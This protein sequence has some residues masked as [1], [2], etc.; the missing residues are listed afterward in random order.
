MN[1]EVI[2]SRY[3]K[4]LLSYVM[5]R[6][7]EEKVYSQVE[8]ILQNMQDVP[9]FRE[10]ILM[11]DDISFS[12]K[13]SLLTTAV[14]EP[15]ADELL[16]FIKLVS[17]HRRMELLQVMFWAFI[18]RYREAKGIKVGALATAFPADG[19]RE[20]METMLESRISSTVHLSEEVDSELIGG[21]VIE[22]DGYRLDASVR[23]QLKKIS[24]EL[25]DKGSRIV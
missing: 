23:T 24:E 21:F 7:V 17:G 11:H 16:N 6:G 8:T 9:Q 20:R 25:I 18:S 15:L 2:S 4:A 13:C 5:E 14:G 19:L 3:A 10:Y 1:T 22:I 12:K